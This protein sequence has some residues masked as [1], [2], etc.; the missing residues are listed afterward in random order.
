MKEIKLNPAQI[1]AVNAIDGPVLVIAGPGTGK[2]QLLSMRVA[3]ILETTDTAPQNILCLTFTNKAAT[4]MRN[5]LF[6]LIGPTAYSVGVHTFHSFAADIMNKNPDYFWNGA[7]LSVVPD[8]VQLAVV[9]DILGSLPLDNPL[10]R[11]F[12]GDLTG[13]KSTKDGLKLAKEAGLTPEKL[14]AIIE[15]NLA[16]IDIAEP[17][18]AKYLSDSLRFKKLHSLQDSLNSDLP[19]QTIENSMAPLLSLRTVMLDS[20]DLAIKQDELTGKTAN[21]GLWKK[22][23]IQTIAS[24]K[25]MNNERNRNN[26]WLALSDVYETYRNTLHSRGYYDYADMLVEVIACLENNADLLSAVQEQYNY[27]L[28]DEFQDTNSAQLRLAHLV[29]DHYANAGKPNLMVVGDDDQS[30]YKF[31]GAELNNMLGFRSFYNIDKP[32]VLSENYR[33]SQNILDVAKTIA[34]QS[35]DRLVNRE[36]DITKNLVA[37][38]DAGADSVI[39]H[40]VYPTQQHQM[41][42]VARKIAEHYKKTPAT[43]IAV[44]ARSHESLRDIASRLQTLKVPVRYEQQNDILK[45]PAIEQVILTARLLVAIYD[46]DEPQTNVLLSQILRSQIWGI[47]AVTLW[48]LAIENRYDPHWLESMI[49]SEDDKLKTLAKGLPEFAQIAVTE[50]LPLVLEYLL[51]LRD[52]ESF[53]SPIKQYYVS[54][55]DLSQQYLETLSAMQLLRSMVDEFSRH[56]SAKLTDFVNFINASEGGNSL[57]SDQTVFTTG[58]RTVELLTVHKAKGLEFDTVFIIDATEKNWRPNSSGRKPPA[59]LPLQPY[60]DDLDD[61]VRLFYVAV[62]RAKQSLIV[63]SFSTDSVGNDILPAPFVRASLESKIAEKSTDILTI[64]EESST[65]PQLHSTDEKLLLRP[66]VEDFRLPVTALINFLDIESGGPQ[67]FRDRNLL[68][69]PEAKSTSQSYGT[70]IHYALEYAQILTNKGNYDIDDITTKFEDA[71]LKEH[72][73]A[74]EFERYHA[75][76]QNMLWTLLEKNGYPLPV[77]SLS[78]QSLQFILPDGTNLGGKLDRVDSQDKSK[79]VIVDYKTGKGLTS[80]Y[81]KNQNYMT[82]AWKHRTQLIFYAL[83]ASLDPRFA[84]FKSTECQMVYVETRDIKDLMRSHTPAKEE[85]ARM[86]KLASKVYKHIQNL[87]FPDISGYEKSIVGILQFEEDLLSD[88]I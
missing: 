43:S 74:N 25:I 36:V 20:L 1:E 12:A 68:R 15:F 50:P 26:W 14:K 3:K 86:A 7:S 78:E 48:H 35:T 11:R 45:H 13:L 31:N 44:L 30:I 82:K 18:L 73:P 64:L 84:D 69:L 66:L 53:H 51:G 57:I 38:R 79:L 2:T 6:D 83:L 77:G 24:E 37:T 32:I 56:N 19:K 41:S 22:R 61:Y 42:D 16:Y 39:E 4:N 23:F 81:T 70:A 75:Q 34:E 67:Y 59:N 80:L 60:G 49:N 9:Q 10:A 29:A 28:I 17:I 62:T 40:V 5:R 8:A 85:V 76:G 72:L 33:S 27:V 58:Q 87:D 63:S 52:H 54:K 21:T 46:G 88:N 71:L 55:R 65:W 47:D